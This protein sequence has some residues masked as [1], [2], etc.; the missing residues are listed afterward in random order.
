MAA[1]VNSHTIASLRLTLQNLEQSSEPGATPAD[2][3]GLKHIL[4]N[5]IAELEGVG[6]LDASPIDLANSQKTGD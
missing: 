4:L 3:D 5:R 1:H 2:L 6:S